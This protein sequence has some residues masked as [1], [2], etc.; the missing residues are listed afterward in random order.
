MKWIKKNLK[1]GNP[2]AHIKKKRYISQ[3]H[4]VAYGQILVHTSI[5][6]FTQLYP[7]HISH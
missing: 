3:F 2:A 6:V 7:L 1:E 4:I 5:V